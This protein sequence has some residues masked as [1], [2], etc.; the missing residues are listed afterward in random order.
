MTEPTMQPPTT[1]RPRSFSSNSKAGLISF[2]LSIAAIL[3][4]GCASF[5][6]VREGYRAIPFYLLAVGLSGVGLAFALNGIN[7]KR[8]QVI[9]PLLGLALNG[10]ALVL[11][12][13]NLLALIIAVS[14]IGP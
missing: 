8:P 5:L 1:V 14:G 4:C 9:P 2:L 10:P 6:V 13:V 11:A 12:C 7:D 3:V